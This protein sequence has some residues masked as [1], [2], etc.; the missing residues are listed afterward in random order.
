[1]QQ[2]STI[3]KRDGDSGEVAQTMYTHVSK[4]DKRKGERKTI[5]KN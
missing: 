3:F 4:N 1:M 5:F 2:V